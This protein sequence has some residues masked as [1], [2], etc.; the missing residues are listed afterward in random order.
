MAGEEEKEKQ[1]GMEEGCTDIMSC[2]N[3]NS[4]SPLG[5]VERA[6]CG[7]R[8]NTRVHKGQL[9]LRETAQR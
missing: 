6:H 5:Q 4:H 2:S 7:S 3:R 8:A 9:G 1:S